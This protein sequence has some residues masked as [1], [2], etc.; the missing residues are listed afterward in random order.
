MVIEPKKIG[1]E[2][3]ASFIRRIGQP[4]GSQKI[5]NQSRVRGA[6]KTQVRSACRPSVEMLGDTGKCFHARTPRA[7]QRAIDVKQ[8]QTNHLSKESDTTAPIFQYSPLKWDDVPLK[9]CEPGRQVEVGH[10]GPGIVTVNL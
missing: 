6:V 8:N 5:A 7:N 9:F 3:P 2:E 1:I 10:D 4:M